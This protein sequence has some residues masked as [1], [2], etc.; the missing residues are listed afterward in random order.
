LNIRESGKQ[1]RNDFI[2]RCR[3]D[4]A[5]FEQ[6][7]KRKKIN[8][9]AKE[10]KITKR[11]TKGVIEEIKMERDL[12]GKLLLISL[13]DKFN[14]GVVLF[15][16]L[17][18]VPWNFF[19]STVQK[20]VTNKAVLCKNLEKRIKSNPPRTIE[21]YIIDGFFFLPLL[22]SNLPQTYEAIARELLI[23]LCKYQ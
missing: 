13:K 12:M 22:S 21:A 19:T 8:T 5:A 1:A 18:Q 6:P 15:H 9:F 7:I 3:D 17:T 4:P 2:Q 10:G 23:K 16:P 11:T 14:I 20:K